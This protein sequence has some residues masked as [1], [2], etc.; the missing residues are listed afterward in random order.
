MP[1]ANRKQEQDPSRSLAVSL[2]R[3]TESPIHISDDSGMLVPI[4]CP[5]DRPAV[6]ALLGQQG[7]ETELAIPSPG[8]PILR[9]SPALERSFTNSVS[10]PHALLLVRA[11]RGKPVQFCTTQGSCCRDQDT[12]PHAA[13]ALR[14]YGGTQSQ[15]A[16]VTA[17]G[18]QPDPSSRLHVKQVH[19]A[20]R[21]P[22][23]IVPIQGL[24]GPGGCKACLSRVDRA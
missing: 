16:A 2:L 13:Q 15:R 14:E 23:G 5:G 10:E 7:S 19:V 11:P 8:S 20:G 24:P 3:T 1:L 18:K 9:A 12:R 6:R 17:L 22:S 21:C 4:P